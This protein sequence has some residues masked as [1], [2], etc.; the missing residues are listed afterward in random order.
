LEAKSDEKYVICNADEG[1]PGAF[2][3]RALLESDPYSVLEGMLIAG[4][5]IRAKQGYVY[6]RAEYPLALAR[7]KN[8]I[9]QLAKC[10]LLGE[11]ILDSGF[12]FQI[13]I[14]E[15]AGAFVCGEETALIASIE[16]KRGMPN[17][18]PPFPATS[19]L[20]KMP[21]VIN[22][23]ETLASV[24]LIFQNS[25]KWFADVGTENSKGTKTF[26]L[27]GKIVR[28]GL[29]EVPLGIKLRDIIYDI[30]G[31]VADNKGFKA[32]QTGGPSGGTI[33]I[34]FL[35]IP[36]DY[37]TLKEL[38]SIMGSG[39]MIVLD[40]D[41]CMVDIARYFLDFTQK[42]SCGKCS[43]CRLG[44]KQMLV[45]L[46]DIT[47]GK[48]TLED[49]DLLAELAETIKL[50][51]LCGLGQTAPNP[52]LTTIKYFEDEY[53]LHIDKKCCLA[54]VCRALISYNILADRCKGCQSCIKVCPAGAIK[55]T[56][57]EVHV[58]DQVRCVKCG[59]CIESCPAKFSAIVCVSGT[60]CDEG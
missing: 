46:E 30:G 55:G 49:L 11:N 28:T 37:E 56:L 27:A 45:I 59:L 44:T 14:K 22:N 47:N 25:A 58:I 36:V 48:A 10:G 35:D 42:E 24:A 52:V 41:T 20:F 60:R 38:G 34:E 39:G 5:T 18:R 33:P 31:G 7:L 13:H 6:C 51:A 9:D 21:T 40:E 4:Y 43:L 23:V 2:M 54:K 1:D 17:V 12:S 50:G 53:R 15:G 57:K 3:N 32:V 26:A 8:A 19:G 16:G 29:I